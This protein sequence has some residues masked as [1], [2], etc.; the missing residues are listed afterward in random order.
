MTELVLYAD[1]H[2]FPPADE[3][4]ARVEAAGLELVPINGHAA[5]DLAP[6]AEHAMALLAWGGPYGADAFDA[7]PRLQILARCGAG[8]DNI[9]LPAARARSITVTYVPGASD[10][11][12]AEHTIAL[13]LGMAR[14]IT[15]SDRAVRAGQWPSAA[16][17]AP[18][19]RVHGSTLGLIGFGRIARAV[20]RRAVALGIAVSAMDPF[21][22]PDVFA[23]ASVTPVTKVDAL[24]ANSDFVSL[25][26]PAV[27]GRGAVIGARELAIMRPGAFLINTARGSLIDTGALVA[28]LREGRLGGAALDVLA[29]EPVPIDHEL[30]ALDNVVITPHS[31]AFSVDALR[32][33]RTRA[34]DEVFAVL[35]GH[36]PITP[37]PEED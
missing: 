31:A 13:L 19:I 14:K 20:A 6:F 27:A 11:E 26:L 17:L 22:S 36:P 21:V 29:P 7:M 4:F 1:A 8:Y 15:S 12:V 28:A 37:V 23:A 25:H 34:L 10:D 30:L 32:S 16:A 35:A 5:S 2:L 9:D 3:D 33:L 18:M 24:L